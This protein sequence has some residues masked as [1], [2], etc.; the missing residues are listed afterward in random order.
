MPNLLDLPVELLLSV[1]TY[2]DVSSFLN[3]TSTCK[4][5]HEPEFL[6]DSAYW[7]TLVRTTFRVPNQPVVQQD[8][9]RGQK[10]FKRMLTQS[11][12]YTWGDNEKGCLGHSFELPIASQNVAPFSMRTL[13]RKRHISWPEQMQKVQGIGV[14]SDLQAGGWSTTLLTSKGAL[15]TVGVIDGH[16]MNH[17]R[18]PYMQKIAVEPVALRYPPG[19]PR[20]C[21][22]YDRSTA[23]KQFSA[24][25]AHILALSDSGRIWS[26]QNI[27]HAAWHVKFLQHDTVEDG[28]TSGQGVVKKVVAG[29]GES[30]ALIEGTGIV[31]WDP[32]QRG[33]GE[34]ETEDTSLIFESTV[35]PNSGCRKP[36]KTARGQFQESD[37]TLAETVGEVLN[38]VVLEHVV[39][40]N[41]HLGK[42]FVAEII[43]ADRERRVAEPVELQVPKAG[44]DEDAFVT[45]VQGSFRSFGVFVRSGAV[46]TSHQEP[47]LDSLHGK[48]GQ[49][50]LFTRIPALQ[51]NGVIQLAF[52]DYHFHALHAPGYIT[53]YGTEPQTCG[54]LGLGGH[55]GGEG[56]LR[57]I[58]DMGVGGDGCLIPHAYAEGRRVWFEKEKQ[59]WITFLTSGGADPAEAVERVRMAIG[60]PGIR[61]QGE[62]SEWVE[63]QGKDWE[64]KYRIADESDDGLGTHF[65]LS[66]TAAGWHSGALVL[67]ND[68]LNN[69]LKQALEV[70]DEPTPSESLEHAVESSPPGISD[71]EAAGATSWL[72]NSAYAIASDWGRWFLGMPPY[73]ASYT[74]QTG[75]MA[76]FQRGQ[77]PIDY[78]AS[79]RA[80]VKYVW[81]NDNFPRLRLR[82]GTEMPGSVPFDDW[83][84]QRPDWDLDFK[85]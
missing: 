17:P 66:V 47:L 78:G 82:D 2:L 84:Y 68:Q 51:H 19:F 55:G 56:R 23:I 79:P 29:W 1:F 10:L 48:L 75:H 52:G 7:S 61:C 37:S 30:A 81:A 54:A 45:D 65:A 16:Q 11:K 20:P 5:L 80:G 50:R 57:G 25:R 69:K 13:L 34:T 70:S 63:Q 40:F 26:W 27:E 60:S 58:R 41:T 44:S 38:V 42:V 83:R 73:N 49:R 35:V 43:R 85:L 76:Q 31:L 6:Y 72:V 9:E 36:R 53:S 59:D 46:L 8:G 74:M 14:V 77:H 15:Y 22:R 3:L 32:L 62:I 71:E 18:R 33:D 4:A 24:G 64:T 21:E 28:R 12:I 67:V 39:L